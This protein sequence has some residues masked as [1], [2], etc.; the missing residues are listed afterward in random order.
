MTKEEIIAKWE[1]ELADVVIDINAARVENN[2]AEKRA[3][4]LSL[5]NKLAQ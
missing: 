3:S 4:S 2:N 1:K 5:G